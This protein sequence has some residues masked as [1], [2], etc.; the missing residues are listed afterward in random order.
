[1]AKDRPD[2]Q[3]FDLMRNK[4]GPQQQLRIKNQPATK[5]PTKTASTAIQSQNPSFTVLS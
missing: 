2:K 1:V 3:A 5:A 4:K